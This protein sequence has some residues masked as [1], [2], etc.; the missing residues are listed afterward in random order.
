[1]FL[2]YRKVD[3]N[4]AK[5]G[6][7]SGSLAC[8]VTCMQETLY[9]RERNNSFRSSVEVN[10]LTPVEKWEIDLTFASMKV[11]RYIKDLQSPIA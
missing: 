8:L 3:R 7:G 5:L 11:I 9:R 10:P 2:D 4:I 1:M 6:K